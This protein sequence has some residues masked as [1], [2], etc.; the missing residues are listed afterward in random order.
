MVVV[1]V[2]SCPPEVGH[3]QNSPCTAEDKMTT[4]QQVNIIF[5]LH[6]VFI[7]IYQKK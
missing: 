4:K 2:P 1:E 3:P 7:L 6:D 5:H